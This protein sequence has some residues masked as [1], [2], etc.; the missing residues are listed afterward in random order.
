MSRRPIE[1]G[2][3]IA[4]GA[5]SRLRGAGW[6]VPKPLIPVAGTPLVE[7]IIRNFMAAG[8]QT[9]VI[10]FNED[11]R[12]C[13]DWVRSRFPGLNLEIIVR[14]TASSLE[15]FRAVCERLG[16]GPAVVSTVD[17]W[18]GE[19]D[20]VEFLA[21]AA[22][23]PSEALVLAVTPLV[24]DERPLWVAMD[25]TGRI[26]SLGDEPGDMVTAGIYVLPEQAP[27]LAPPSGVGRG[28]R[29]SQCR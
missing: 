25:A 13:E 6:T 21:A 1:R 9:V 8:I 14:T 28:V 2:G 17:A 12:D 4:A 15:S 3:I 16:E 29:P 7:R 11:E 10:I 22:H 24:A 18:C 26:A 19:R 20:F 27:R 5:G 23:C